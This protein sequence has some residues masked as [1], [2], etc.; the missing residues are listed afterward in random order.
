M[1]LTRLSGLLWLTGLCACTLAQPTSPYVPPTIPPASA[2]PAPVPPSATLPPTLTPSPSPTPTATPLPTP[3][4]ALLLAY[5]DAGLAAIQ[6]HAQNMPVLCLRHEDTDADGAPEWLALVHQEDE[7]PHLSAFI[8]DGDVA[9]WLAPAHPQPGVPDVGLGQYAVCDA[10]IRDV[11][12]DGVPEIAIFGHT[13]K[14]ET[15]LH[16]FTW[17]GTDY[18]RLGRFSGDAGVRFMDAD[19]DLELEIWEGYRDQSAPSLA[20]YVIHTWEDGTYGWTSDCYAWYALE[21]PHSYPT[22]KAEYAVISF[23]LALDDRDLSG[24]YAL[25]TPQ[26]TR[27]YASWVL[28]YATTVR[29]SVGDA[30]PI[31]ASVTA[32]SA[33]VSAMVTAWDNQG[34]IIMARLW[35]VEWDTVRTAAGWRLVD[36]T[37]D[38]LEEWTVAYWP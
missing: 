37:T 1:Q 31:P 35:N 21:R 5:A 25:L 11:N 38:L 16:L 6:E 36:A 4:P 29:V 3:D 23:Y 27:D 24:A 19:G 22:H 17:D 15:L 26:D 33:R 9:Y 12:V 32:N 30:H 20:W 7:P 28:G 13:E 18:R 14:N 10:D 8:L 34:G 2:T